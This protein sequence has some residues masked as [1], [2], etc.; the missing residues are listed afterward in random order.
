M[1]IIFFDTETTDL[2]P[3]R[4]LVQLAYK[5]ATTGYICNEYFKPPV[6]ISFGAM[7]IHHITNEMVLDRPAFQESEHYH[8]FAREVAEG[9]SVAHNAPFDIEVLRNEGIAIGKYIDTLRVAKH[10]LQCERYNLQYLRYYL[11]LGAEGDAHD[12]L[13]DITVL[14]ALF[15]KLKEVAGQKFET[16]DSAVLIE[17][18][19]ELTAT[20]PL[21]HQIAFGKHKG[22]TF[23]EVAAT[24]RNYLEWL[25]GSELQKPIE[26]QNQE[27]LLT[28]AHHLG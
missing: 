17:K 26:Q 16:S 9:I 27:L 3:N 12:A 24:D 25:R 6:E 20:P 8:S 11:N 19:M 21:L 13:G 28:L 15:H 22:K 23:Q 2:D 7:S 1:N 5:N 4:R 18:M 14:E 10:L